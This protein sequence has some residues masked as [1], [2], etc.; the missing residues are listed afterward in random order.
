MEEDRRKGGKREGTRNGGWRRMGE[1]GGRGE[2]KAHT[3]KSRNLINGVVT[4]IRTEGKAKGFPQDELIQ[5]ALKCW[6]GWGGIERIPHWEQILSITV[7][8]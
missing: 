4:Q 3:E 6:R 2:R 5:D 7:K 8:K 1:A